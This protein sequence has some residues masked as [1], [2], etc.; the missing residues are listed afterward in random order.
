MERFRATRRRA[1]GRLAGA[2]SALS[3]GPIGASRLGSIAASRLGPTL[4][5]ALGLALGPAAGPALAS[6]DYPRKALRLVVGYP[7]GGSADFV[8]RVVADEL[9]RVIGVPV[10]VENR[11]G[12]GGTIANEVVA[13]A[14]PDGYTVLNAAPHAATDA[15]YPRLPYDSDK[16]FVPVINLATAP[17]IVLVNNDLPVKNLTDLIALARQKPGAL[18]VASSGN[19]STPHLA[20]ALFKSVAGV[21]LTVIHFRGGAAAASSTIAGD[22][23][24]MFSTPPTVMSFIQAGRLRPLAV[25]Q[26]RPSPAIP[27]IPGAAEAGLDG[28]D[29]TFS[30]GL[31]LPAGTPAAI[32]DKLQQASHQGMLAPGVAEKVASQ[33][34][35][36]D[37]TPSPAEF[38]KRLTAAAPG[39]HQLVR[40][41]GARLE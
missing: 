31:Y 25:T 29:A 17:M 26:P 33:G 4:A 37:L 32:V 9:V 38:V 22:T 20:A 15:L 41:S 21:D 16:D 23:Q 12:A 19:G 6:S 18:N 3:R 40:D 13:K 7:P 36:V 14:A 2:G 28:Y 1:L 30:F 11:P 10:V 24:I 5:P 35:D 39:M 34:M 27:G 8:S